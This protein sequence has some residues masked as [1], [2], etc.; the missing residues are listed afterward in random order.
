M[1]PSW[2]LSRRRAVLAADSFSKVTEADLTL[3]ASLDSGVTE[4][5]EILPLEIVR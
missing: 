2:V 1:A 3:S 5:F 4:M